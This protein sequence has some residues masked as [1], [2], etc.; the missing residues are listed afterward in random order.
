MDYLIMDL[1]IRT[2]AD[3]PSEVIGT[4]LAFDSFR[5]PQPPRQ[6]GDILLAGRI[7]NKVY[8]YSNGSWDSGLAIPSSRNFY[9]RCS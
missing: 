4:G 9:D 6:Y 3:L 7:D 8:R 1:G 5:V 2:V